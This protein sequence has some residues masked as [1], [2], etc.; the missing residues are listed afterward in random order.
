[1]ILVE[2]MVDR[3]R[4]RPDNVAVAP[5]DEVR[6]LREGVVGVL[7]GEQPLRAEQP[8]AEI[9]RPSAVASSRVASVQVPREL[10][11]LADARVA[12]AEL[13]DREG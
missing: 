12:E 10:C 1:M 9:D 3:C 13:L 5:R 7:G 6:D 11:E 8:V 2:A 4:D